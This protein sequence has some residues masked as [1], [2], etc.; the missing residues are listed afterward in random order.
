MNANFRLPLS[1]DIEHVAVTEFGVGIDGGRYSFFAV[2]IDGNVQTALQDMVK[3]TIRILTNDEEGD[4]HEQPRTYNPAERYGSEEHLTLPTQSPFAAFIRQVHQAAN[5]PNNASVLKKPA[6][7]FCYFVRLKDRKGKRL[8]AIRRA[9]QFKGILRARLVRLLTDSL[10][11]VKDK[12]FKLDNDFDLLMDES[13]IHILRSSSF[14]FLAKTKEAVL[15]AV[16]ENITVIQAAMPFVDFGRIEKYARKHARAARYLASIKAQGGTDKIDKNL[17][18]SWC[19][20]TN[21]SV[22]EKDGRFIVEEGYEMDFL[23]L[24]DRRRYEIE[25]IPKQPERFRAMSRRRLENG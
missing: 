23:E 5:L 24:L 10:A 16:P 17:L 3:E 9:T 7:I 4:A 21:V 18:L 2:P 6:D 19:Q 25:L 12:I 20:K 15:E 8:T 13:L 14:E 22:E 11:L 1:F